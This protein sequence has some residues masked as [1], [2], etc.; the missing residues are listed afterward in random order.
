MGPGRDC[1]G[2]ALGL[3]SGPGRRWIQ[4]ELVEGGGGGGGGGLW[5]CVYMRVRVGG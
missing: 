5:V 2:Q 3:T 4:P 1:S